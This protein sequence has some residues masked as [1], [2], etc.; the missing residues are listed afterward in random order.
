MRG[1]VLYVFV[2]L[3][4]CSLAIGPQDVSAA[5]S[6]ET[7][8]PG[9]AVKVDVGDEAATPQAIRESVEKQ[10]NYH[11]NETNLKKISQ[12][13]AC[14]SKAVKVHAQRLRLNASLQSMAQTEAS[15]RAGH[16]SIAA[17]GAVAGGGVGPAAGVQGPPATPAGPTLGFV[18]NSLI[19]TPS[20]CGGGSGG[21][22]N[23]T[24][25]RVHRVVMTPQ[26]ASDDFGYRL[27]RRYI[28]Y[29]V[30]IENGSKDFQFMLQ[31]VTID[32]SLLYGQPSGTYAYNASSQ[33]L[34]L[35]R[36]VPEKGEDHDPRNAVLHVLQGIG[37]VAGAVSGLTSF[38][39]VMGSSVA[40]FNGAFLQGYTTISPDHTG[41]Q[42]NRLSDSA[43]QA[44]TIVDKLRAKTIAMFIPA[45]EVL[46]RADQKQFRKDPNG[47]L[48]IGTEASM[49][50]KADVCVDGTFI[51]SVTTAAPTLSAAVVAKSPAPA[52]G[53]DTTLA[54]TGNNLVAGDT[55]VTVGSGATAT[56]APVITTD[57]KTGTAQVHLPSD[58]AT[59]TTTAVLSSKSNPSLTSGTG[60]KITLPPTL[61]KAELAKSPAP[62]PG[63]D[64]DMTITGTDMVSGDTQVVIGTGTTATTASVTTSDGKTG[65]AKVH[66]PSDY[67]A[68][69]LAIL[70]SKS[71]LAVNSGAGV[72]VT[73]AP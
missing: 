51:Q 71:N 8:P 42:L 62:A 27:G 30:T 59:G 29:Q 67:T 72:A 6:D 22:N 32:F 46:S 58:Y 28:V 43:F 9:K 55:Q 56:T 54:V 13:N 5:S 1:S 60:V 14:I 11:P 17:V 41:T 12:T 73:V 65:T 19:G 18:G 44:N 25:I 45:D 2:C 57:G 21:I 52:P 70:Q 34:T 33:D 50:D 16:I 15:V 68:T 3:I 48:G 64:T 36:G 20:T 63:V 38:S 49:L 37:S 47:F 61:T 4:T 35:L 23:P 39:D 26:I 40:V 7:P 69:T 31:D 66:L 53:L 10:C 24:L